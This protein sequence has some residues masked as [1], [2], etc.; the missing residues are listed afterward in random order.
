MDWA[1]KAMMMK[2]RTWIKDPDSLFNK[3]QESNLLEGRE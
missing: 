2:T 3:S 1:R